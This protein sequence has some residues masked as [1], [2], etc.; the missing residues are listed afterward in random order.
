[1]KG[2]DKMFKY[3]KSVDFEEWCYSQCYSKKHS[4]K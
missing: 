2:C 4:T 1:M 3:D